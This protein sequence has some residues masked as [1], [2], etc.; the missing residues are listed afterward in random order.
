[1]AALLLATVVLPAVRSKR[2]AIFTEEA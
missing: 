1:V 2:A